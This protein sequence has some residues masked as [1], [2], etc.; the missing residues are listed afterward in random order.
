MAVGDNN[1]GRLPRGGVPVPDPTVL[2]TQQ[3]LREIQLLRELLDVKND[4]VKDILSSRM[5]SIDITI[6]LIEGHL[7]GITE[8]AANQI[9]RLQ[10]LHNEK[11]ESVQMMFMERDKRTEQLALADKT[12]IA[13][14]L[15]AQKEA[16]NAQ[17]IANATA[18]T[19]T[20]A[21]FTK[22]IEQLQAIVN[23]I[24]QSMEDKISDLKGR[25]D[26]S[27]AKKVGGSENWIAIL[28]A[29]GVIISII[30]LGILISSHTHI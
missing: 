11:F 24:T 19:K 1:E 15:Q 16:V 6:G 12:A 23:T 5:D 4:S 18:Q 9:S 2:T 30:T 27:E 26:T 21:A 8:G 17:N 13:A 20:E 14:A 25:V 28:G 10:E 3:L 7:K 29:T 22:Q